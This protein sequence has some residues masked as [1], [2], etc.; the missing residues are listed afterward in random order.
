MFSFCVH[1][2]REVTNTVESTFPHYT[3]LRDTVFCRF[4]CR[5]D[6]F[7]SPSQQCQNAE[8]CYN[9]KDVELFRTR[10]IFIYNFGDGSVIVVTAGLQ[11]D[12]PC[13]CVYILWHHIN[14]LFTV[15]FVQ[16]GDVWIFTGN[17]LS[18]KNFKAVICVTTVIIVCSDV[19]LSIIVVAV[20]LKI[21]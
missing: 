6:A 1:F 4:S 14:D 2:L 12:L 3:T 8:G 20:C 21:L 7:L 16:C 10:R 5:L 13:F 15:Y 18:H 19:A 17:F 9:S 11:Q